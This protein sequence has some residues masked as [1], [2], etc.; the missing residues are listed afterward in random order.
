M[1]QLGV[2]LIVPRRLWMRCRTFC[3]E[4]V[5]RECSCQWG[6]PSG[7]SSGQHHK[8]GAPLTEMMPCA[9]MTT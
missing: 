7:T 5:P 3:G 6:A 2:T 8:T 4:G 9:K 1:I